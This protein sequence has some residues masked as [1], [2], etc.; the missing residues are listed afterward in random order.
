MATRPRTPTPA[1]RKPAP[2]RARAAAPELAKLTRPR[3]FS[4]T[5]R[6]RLFR[7]LDELRERPAVWITGAPGSGKSAFVASYLDARR[8]PAVWYNIDA[9]DRDPA[10][11][12]YYLGLAAA[13]FGGTRASKLPLFADEYRRDLTGFARSSRACRPARSSCSTT[14]TRPRGA[15]RRARRCWPR[16]RPA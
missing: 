3:L 13:P 6:E 8:L 14:C 4:V 5:P 11:F 16:S 7:L 9:G 12:F 2:P 10:T 15:A 1:A